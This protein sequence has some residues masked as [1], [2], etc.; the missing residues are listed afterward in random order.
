MINGVSFDDFHTFRDFSLVLSK[1][2]IKTPSIKT[3]K[4]DIE[5]MDGVL[6]ITDYFGEVTY[7]NRSL[8][9]EFTTLA[10]F[11]D[12]ND[13]FSKIQN[14]LHG[15]MMKIVIDDD[16]SYYYIGRVNVN[17]WKS[18]RRIGKIVIECDCEP[19]KYKKYKT[20]I[21]EEIKGQRDF[22][23]LNLRKQVIPLFKSNGE[24]QITFGEQ[25]YSIGI[26][27]YTLEDVVLKEGKNILSVS[28]NATLTIEYQERGL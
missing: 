2:T 11:T 3:K 8:S 22:V 9:F 12:F 10:N 26:G 20:I 1:K 5:G 27:E 6:D 19:Y 7:E 17:E 14:A 25:I 23:L 21:T 18:N 15:K 13:L 28:G 24:L 4:V 16:A